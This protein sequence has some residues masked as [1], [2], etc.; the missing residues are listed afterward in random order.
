[1]V[2]VDEPPAARV[3]VDAALEFGLVCRE[4]RGQAL[5]LPS[6]VRRRIVFQ[7]DAVIGCADM[8]AKSGFSPDVLLAALQGLEIQRQR[9]DDQI[10]AVLQMLGSAP[11]LPGRKRTL[12]AAARRRIAAAQRRRW[13]ALKGP[14]Q[15]PTTAKETATPEIPRKRKLSAAGRKAIIEATK[16]R[17]AEQ[18]K[19]ERAEARHKAEAKARRVAALAKA[20]KTLAASRKAA[21]RA[22][23]TNAEKKPVK[24]SAKKATQKP[25]K[26]TAEAASTAVEAATVS[27]GE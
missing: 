25:M 11:R 12:S 23:L 15:I 6:D 22:A 10:K 1:M 26:K 7:H 13:A 3:A 2:H 20:R 16:K 21:R 8:P 14:K 4:V 19:R 27:T 18:R 5:Q 9:I 17:W 24:K